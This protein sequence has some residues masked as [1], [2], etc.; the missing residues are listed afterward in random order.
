[1]RI[2]AAV[3]AL[4]LALSPAAAFAGDDSFAAQARA[5][6]N[7]Q[8]DKKEGKDVGRCISDTLK[9]WRALEQ[10]YNQ[11]ERKKREDWKK[12]HADMGLTTEYYK[13]YEAFQDELKAE[14]A[15]FRALQ[16]DLQ[17]KAQDVWQ[18][19]RTTNTP[20]GRGTT[21]ENEKVQAAEKKCLSVKDDSAHRACMRR[22][23]R[24]VNEKGWARTR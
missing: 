3:L 19:R 4:T 5:Q 18:G 11:L 15:E 20:Q 21:F 9:Q 23:L 22:Y 10:S 12:E 8:C 7:L 6:L 16:K 24:P 14:R 17:K 2:P 13:L 1:M